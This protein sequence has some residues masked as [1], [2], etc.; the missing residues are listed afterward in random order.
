MAK[1]QKLTVGMVHQKIFNKFD[2][3]YKILNLD[4]YDG[5]SQIY[6]DVLCTTCNTVFNMKLYGLLFEKHQCDCP[7]CRQNKRNDEF[8]KRV[9]NE[10][11]NEY[12]PI[13]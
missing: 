3:K 7:T 6:I 4:T 12:V 9:K 13:I 11:G 8:I 5:N 10:C 1:G 2:G